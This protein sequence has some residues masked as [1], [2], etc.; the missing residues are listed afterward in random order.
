MECPYCGVEM[1]CSDYY[2]KTKHSEHYWIYPHSWIEKE[3]DIYKCPNCEGFEEKD[4]AIE[5]AKD[6]NIEYNE[7]EWEYIVCE[8]GI[9]NGYFYTDRNGNL[10]EGYPC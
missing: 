4:Q 10:H 5:Y 3:G 8:S 6:N 7:D 2:G 9:F 1:N